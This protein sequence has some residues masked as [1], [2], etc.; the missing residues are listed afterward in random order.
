M[1]VQIFSQ[2]EFSYS[3]DHRNNRCT[4]NLTR[5]ADCDATRIK[6]ITPWDFPVSAA[7]RCLHVYFLKYFIYITFWPGLYYNTYPYLGNLA[8]VN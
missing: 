8:C 6:I 7:R 1:S 3:H 5:R 4:T 2:A